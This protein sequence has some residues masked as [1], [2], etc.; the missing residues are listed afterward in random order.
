MLSLYCHFHVISVL[1][2]SCCLCLATFILS[3]Y[4]HFH[5][6]SA[7]SFSCCLCIVIFILSFYKLLFPDLSGCKSE[8]TSLFIDLLTKRTINQSFLFYQHLFVQDK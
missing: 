7:L 8:L 2:F 5:V 4:C 6:V 1:S 3:L